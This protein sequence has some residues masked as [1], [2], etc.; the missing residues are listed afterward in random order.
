[1][2][3]FIFIGLL[4]VNFACTSAKKETVQKSEQPEIE[5]TEVSNDPEVNLVVNYPILLEKAHL[6][7]KILN[8]PFKADSAYFKKFKAGKGLKDEEIKL[9]A[10]NFRESKDYTEGYIYD[11]VRL[12]HLKQ[13]DRY[14]EY[15]NNLDLAQL[16]DANANI[17]GKIERNDSCFIV[18]SIDY[19]SYEACP[20]YSGIEIYCSFIQDGIV[21][22]CLKLGEYSSSGDAPV[23]GESFSTFTI[24]KDFTVQRRIHSAYYDDDV[25]QEKKSSKDM[26]KL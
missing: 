3:K 11:V 17:I 18:W 2:L 5:N 21:K 15:V 25:L 23:Y 19:C 8:L 14:E 13:M 1:M 12:N 10:S 22:K 4:F 16:K 6:K 24:H 20:F 9:L 26:I 7:F